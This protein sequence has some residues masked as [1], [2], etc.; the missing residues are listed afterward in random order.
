MDLEKAGVSLIMVLSMRVKGKKIAAG[1]VPTAS[2]RLLI[3][4]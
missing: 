4:G 1:E 2:V 3:T